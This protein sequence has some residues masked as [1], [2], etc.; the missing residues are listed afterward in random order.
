MIMML[1]GMMLPAFGQ[2]YNGS[3]LEFGKN[4]VQYQKDRLWFYYRFQ[5]FNTYHYRGGKNLAI[6][7]Y[8][9]ANQQISKM[10]SLLDYQLNEKAHFVI[11]NSLNDLKESNIGL[12]SD[13]QYNV[14]GVTH[15]VGN[16]VFLYFNGDHRHLEKQI[17]MGIANILV[18]Q[19][20][21]GSNVG[22]AVKN[23]T[24]L[25]LPEWYKNGLISYLSEEWNTEIDNYV[26][27]GIL[28][29]RYDNFNSLRGEDATYAGHSIWKYIAD[30]YGQRVV[31][32][33]VYMTKASRNIE[34]AF[35]YILG[36]S[37]KNLINDWQEHYTNMY[38]YNGQNRKEIGDDVVQKRVREK[39]K[40]YNPR[41]SP[42]GQ[43]L[44]YA[45]NHL[46]KL[47]IYL[48]NLQTGKR[49]KILRQGHKLDQ[50]VDYS[51]PLVAWH[52]SSK[53]FTMI[54]ERRGD[55]MIYYFDMEKQKLE[56]QELFTVEKVLDI[57][58]N[59]KG[60]KLVLSAVKDG[61][62]DLFV[63]TVGSETFE[64]I[65]NDV[66]DEWH[67]RFINQS[68]DIVF[69]S[70]RHSD[71]LR[72]V[73]LNW[74]EKRE[75]DSIKVAS[76]ADIFIYHYEPKSRVLWRL[77][78]TPHVDETHPEEF[79]KGYVTYLSDHNG[80]KNRY[81]AK[82]DSAVNYVDTVVH[83]RYFSR[84]FPLSDY[85]QSILDHDISLNQKK[86][87]EH[88]Y[89][90][91]KDKLFVRD[92]PE[93][94]AVD[95]SR[96]ENTVYRNQMIAQSHEEAEADTSRQSQKSKKEIIGKR[97]VPLTEND[98]K[99][100]VPQ[101]SGEVNIED[102]VFEDEKQQK[103]EEQSQTTKAPG[104]NNYYVEYTINKLI[105]QVD[106]SFMDESY[107]PFTGGGA[108]IFLN[109]GFSGLFMVGANDLMEDYRLTGGVRLSPNLQNNE[110][111]ISYEN[112]KNRL[113]QQWV[114]HRKSYQNSSE[115]VMQKIASH[116]IYYK[117]KYPVNQVFSARATASIRY[118][119]ATIM[120]TDYY[121]L[122]VPNEFYTWAGL[123]A[124]LVFD[125]TRDRGINTLFGTR[126]KAFGEYFQLLDDDRQNIS[127]F[128]VGFDIRN[129]LPVHRSLIWANRLAA[130]SSFGNARLIYYMGGVDN[131]ITPK[132]NQNTDI[133]YEQNYAFQTLATPMRGFQQNIRN[134]NTFAL[135][136]SE[137]RFPFIRYFSK[138][139]IKSEFLS[140]LQLIGF[141]DAG[142]AWTGF[143]PYSEENTIEE[144]EYFQNPFHVTVKRTTEPIVGGAGAG[145]R[146]KLF[147]YFV[148]FD[149]AWGY[150]E[151]EVQEPRL[152]LSFNLDF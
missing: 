68:Q 110:Y 38:Q 95:K 80:I 142:S 81:I 101:D 37:Y 84:T 112:L 26:R 143:N 17:R 144:T 83:Y 41:I 123:K 140:S 88:V 79:Q 126:G 86:L 99:E 134:G 33:V 145:L 121:T 149:Y 29:E 94:D 122:Q 129:Y 1:S 48:K 36:V 69:S 40:Y 56:K 92:L 151:G 147:G 108:P 59:H 109:P 91:G 60:S 34:S 45:T 105:S 21:T 128:V 30:N 4:R 42:D 115:Y 43:W 114:F 71:T 78:N 74:R 13:E 148:R 46:G 66:Y 23:S 32:N 116:N 61:Q 15:L 138:K 47:K 20:L 22:S 18:N 28:T 85:S 97:F 141:L 9:Y 63:Y 12:I 136:N 24:L 52:P 118:D 98:L 119:R 133:N 6:Y 125:N 107:Q 19:M 35:L 132:F 65:T 39:K 89:H 102:Y 130:S 113:D 93:I 104:E 70:N 152:Y 124:E 127:M 96:I 76:Y 25:T 137:L 11:F 111:M 139:P 7:T 117:I 51:Y 135:F 100:P 16:K 31:P 53:L 49:K 5:E 131:W 72:D 58:Y 82:F 90:N 44:V 27:D 77:T 62:T 14:G 103:P 87:V 8:R 57:D 2:F 10:Q 3:Q 146:A 120:A 67:P 54:L 73:R 55:N 106:F 75:R 64:Q 150:L 50:K